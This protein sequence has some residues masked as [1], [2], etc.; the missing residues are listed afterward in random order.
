MTSRGPIRDILAI[1][2]VALCVLI[3]MAALLRP[4]K[5]FEP[6]LPL[7]VGAVVVVVRHYF[8]RQS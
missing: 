1:A 6:L 7:V 4:G 2:V 5:G 8:G 3:V